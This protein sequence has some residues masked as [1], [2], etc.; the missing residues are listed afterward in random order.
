MISVSEEN[1]T[2][3]QATLLLHKVVIQRAK[4]SYKN[5]LERERIW[6]EQRH[7]FSNQREEPWNEYYK[8][9]RESAQSYLAIERLFIL[10]P[11]MKPK[12]GMNYS[13]DYDNDE[14]HEKLGEIMREIGNRKSYRDHKYALK[15]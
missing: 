5:K 8:S 4:E 3:K 6:A 1:S 7:I 15:R 11:Q 9:I 14:A 13:H 10:R 12:Y 2:I